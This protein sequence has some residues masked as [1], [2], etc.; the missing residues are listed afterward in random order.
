VGASANVVV[1]NVS[2][3]AGHEISFRTF[4]RYGVVV[5]VVSLA[6]ST[7]YVYGRYLMV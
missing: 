3:R 7:V 2:A 1:A 5:T 6:I 4:V